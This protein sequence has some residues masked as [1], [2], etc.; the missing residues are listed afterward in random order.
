MNKTR[1]RSAAIRYLLDNQ[2]GRIDHVELLEEVS[3]WITDEEL[4]LARQTL[5]S[6]LISKAMSKKDHEQL[7]HAIRHRDPQTGSDEWVA[8]RG[9]HL[10]READRVVRRRAQGGHLRLRGAGRYAAH[11]LREGKDVR[12]ALAAERPIEAPILDLRKLRKVA[13]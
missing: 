5:A 12:T 6:Q 4:A 3:G 9:R 1:G 2:R 11:F 13:S 8:V 7:V 10:K